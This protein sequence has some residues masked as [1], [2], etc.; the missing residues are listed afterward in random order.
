M[1]KFNFSVL[2]LALLCVFTCAAH[3][4]G[5]LL[6]QKPTLSPT[7][8]A[9]SYAGDLWLVSREGGEARLLTSGD[10]TKSDPVFS[11]DGAMIAFT[12]DYDGNV[13]VYVMPAS[14]GVPRRLT[15]HPAVDEVVGWTPDGK[16]VLFRSSRNSYSGFN[17]LF[18][19]S[20]EGGLPHELPLPTAEGGSFSPDG[21]HIAYI[22]VDNNRRLSA[23]GWKRY[24]GGKASRIWLANLSDLSIHQLPRESSNDGNP[25]W[26]GNKVYF[27][28]D[29]NGPFSLFAYD[30]GTSKVEQ[31]IP[32]NG[33]DIKSASAGPGAIVYE[34]F[35]SLNLFDLATGKAKSL[36]VT[37]PADLP[38][39]RAH[40][41]K[42]ENEIAAANLSPSGARAVF[43]AHGEILTAPADKGDVRNLTNTPGV[44]ERDPAWSPDGKWVAYFSDESGEY[45]LFLKSPDG[46]GEPKKVSL[47]A[48]PSFYYN[49]IWS[50]DSKKIAYTDKR[51]NVWYVD[52][53]KG[54]PVKVDSDNYDAPQRTLDPVW[55]PDSRWIAYTKRLTSH[56]RAVFAYS[57]EQGKS[58]QLT[59]GLSDARFPAFDQKGQ[60]LYF[61]ASTDDGPTTGW[62][63]L[64][65][66]N[67]PVTRSAYLIVLRKDQASPLAPQSDEEKSADESKADSDK[68][69]SAKQEDKD[70]E[71]ANPEDKAK[72]QD[73]KAARSVRAEAVNVRID[74]ENIDQRIL[75]LPIPPRN[76]SRLAAG[77]PGVIF[78]VESP[79]RPGPDEQS[80]VWRFDLTSRK[81]EKLIDGVNEFMLSFDGKKTLYAKGRGENIK[82][83][84]G[85]ATAP[86][87]GEGAGGAA[88]GGKPDTALNLARMEVLVDPR[89]EWRQEYN[90]VWRIERD[91]FYDPNLHGLNLPATRKHYEAYLENVGNRVDFSYLLAEMLGEISVGHMYIRTPAGPPS[92]QGKVGL[93]GADY[94]IENGRYRFSHI[95]QG[96]NWNPQLRAPLTQP[97]VNVQEGEYLLAVN[98]RELRG[99]DEIFELFEGTATKATVLRVSSSP[100]GKNARNVTVMPVDN[101]RALR[102]RAWI[103]ENR[104]KVDQLSGGRLAYVYLPDTGFGGYTS[105][106][107]YFFA[108]LGREGAVIDERFNGGGSAADY[109]IDYLRRPL[110]N[111][112]MTREGQD[113]TTPVGAIFGP[114]AMIINMYAGSGG[115]ALPWYFRDAKLGPLVG[116]RTWGGLV[117]IYDYP[118]LMDGGS[119][120][121][122][123]V[124]FYNRNG[125]WDVENHGVAPD[126]EVELTPKE[127]AGGH[128]PQLE[129]AVTL[130][131]DS[132]KKNPLPVAKRPTFPNYHNPQGDGGV[133]AAAGAG[134]AGHKR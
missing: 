119:V 120:T 10:G 21:K 78:L 70:E 14:G 33:A 97:G 40:F 30:L 85:S 25:M 101:D 128:D 104:R 87:R 79:L 48:P 34:Q 75:A 4:G 123:R 116:T 82:W 51:L 5:P 103:D 44:M 127:W 12:G 66:I 118:Q 59:D 9:F 107:R 130:V 47:G 110:Q 20:L 64:S 132:L 72:A 6:M 63:D 52:L 56:M 88:A 108:Q 61:T 102:N 113:F 43:E 15:H 29:R 57:L 11:P 68:S 16:Q 89:A 60:Y 84:I 122:P 17:R 50:P 117:G 73:A 23:I 2:S 105:F 42:V 125:E 77:R 86:A 3:A 83:Y 81:P 67:R 98:G 13:D 54:A 80:S 93:L 115:D 95:Y 96:E 65:S 46:L 100:D 90:E 106:N 31:V 121:A 133:P 24:R 69:A 39:V 74:A 94:T 62:L 19:V 92:E 111:Y 114:K 49:P 91:F 8:I 1:S 37:V 126:Y 36:A 109:V 27:L 99:A 38:N 58:L 35:G 18:T 26:V 71:P 129:K 53:A 7:H 124:A 55:S 45:Q 41:K 112:W 131:M 32:A 22:P 76:Y 28:S 134:S